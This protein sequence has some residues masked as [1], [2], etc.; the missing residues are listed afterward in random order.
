[1]RTTVLDTHSLITPRYAFRIWSQVGERK[2]GRQ[3]RRK[4]GRKE[5]KEER[6]GKERKGKE[7]KG[8]ERKGKEREREV[9]EK[10][11]KKDGRK[12]GKI[13]QVL[14]ESGTHLT[15]KSNTLNVTELSTHD[16]TKIG[17]IIHFSR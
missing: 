3:E 7:R 9:A 4:E 16:N 5:R 1:M 10:E 15:L 11:G 17:A 2:E 8:K 6:K 14:L 12:R 13:I